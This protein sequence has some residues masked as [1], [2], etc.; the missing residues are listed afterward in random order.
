LAIFDL[1]G[2]VVESRLDWTRIKEDLGIPGKNILKEIYKDGGVDLERL[3][4]LERY[5]EKNTRETRPIAGIGKFL[6]FL[7]GEEVV[8]ALTTN[9]NL[10]N[11][12]Y[13]LSK[14]SLGFDA[15]IT[16]ETGF[17]KPD[18][19]AFLHLME[20]FGCKADR[21]MVIGDS[22][23]DVRAAKNAGIADIFIINANFFPDGPPE[24]IT[25]FRDYIDLQ[26]I[27]ERK[28]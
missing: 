3:R 8:R 24:G 23:Y 20:R 12:Q 22:H 14:F 1:D 28:F 5:E 10:K 13:L 27:L 26:H 7:K 19:D 4:R 2:T 17:W 11:T 6:D 15:V 9:N 21:A 16:R 25:Y 18:P